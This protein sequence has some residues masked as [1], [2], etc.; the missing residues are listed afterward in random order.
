MLMMMMMTGLL[1]ATA[2]DLDEATGDVS[3]LDDVRVGA[4]G[5]SSDAII[6]GELTDEDDFPMTGGMLM[7]ASIMNYSFSSFVCSSTLIAPDVVLL[8]AHCLDEYVFTQGYGDLEDKELWWTRQAD[9]TEWDGSVRIPELP[10]DAVEVIGYTIHQDFS[11]TSMGLRLSENY[12]IA[13]MFLAEPLTDAP[14]A[15]LPTADEATQLEVDAVVSVVGWGQQ[16]ATS[17]NQAP[18]AGSYAIKVAGESYIAE[19]GEH[20]FQVGAEEDDVRKCHG[21]SG[22]P[23][24]LHVETSSAVSRRLIGV[25]SHAYDLTDCAEKGGVDTRVDAYLEWIDDEMTAAC[26]D[27]IRVWCDGVTGILPPP[28]PAVAKNDEDGKAGCSAI[29][30]SSGALTAGLAGLIGLARRRRER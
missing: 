9:L 22:G 21:D 7:S 5:P 10:E 6:N 24:F 16:V 11:L 20:E 27:G 15:Y 8:A 25:T 1:T 26:E 17:R 23:S 28:A 4:V 19:L 30:A 3:L 2:Q 29:A 12:D 13:V 18:P 14:L